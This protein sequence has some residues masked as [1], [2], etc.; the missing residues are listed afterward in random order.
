MCRP[1]V[2]QWGPICNYGMDS[3][4]LV[5]AP[6]ATQ[7]TAVYVAHPD[8]F[9]ADG[10]GGWSTELGLV[11]SAL[12]FNRRP[13]N[14]FASASWAFV[15]YC[16]GDLH[17]GNTTRA[18]NTKVG[19]F[20]PVVPRTHFFAGATNMD[21]YLA[22]LRARHPSVR[23]VYLVGVSGG[24][25][26]AQLNLHRVRQV[27]PEALVH[28]L[29]DSA[30]M[31]TTPYFDAMRREWNLQV[32]SACTTCDAGFP[33]IVAEQ[34]VSAPTSRV[35]L[36]SF[37]EDQVITRFFFSPGNTG[38]WATPPTS[39]YVAALAQLEPIYEANTNSKF[40]RRAGQDHVMLQLAGVVLSDG[41][42]TPPVSS[43]DGGV[44]LLEWVQGWATDGGGWQSQR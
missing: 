1:S 34:I 38:G 43:A 27:F 26:G 4:C 5:D 37:S 41:G 36:L 11:R 21:S 10:G 12:L 44:T 15:P 6:G 30:P 23:V 29:A 33:A 16:T 20:D 7:P 28:V 18:Y 17:A 32:P 25:Y 9:P 40:F 42:L 24:G 13:E 31:V 8:P 2:Y 3:F 22:W 14:P 35:A 39:A 19:L